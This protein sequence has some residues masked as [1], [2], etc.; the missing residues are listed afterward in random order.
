MTVTEAM[1]AIDSDR[2]AGHT[3]LASNVKAFLRIAADQPEIH[4]LRG[5]SPT[6]R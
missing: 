3:N 4:A 2:I 5:F 6:I 1:Q